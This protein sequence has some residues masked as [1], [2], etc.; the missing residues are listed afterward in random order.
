MSRPLQFLLQA[1]CA[2]LLLLFMPASLKELTATGAVHAAEAGLPLRDAN[3]QG[4]ALLHTFMVREQAESLAPA[5]AQ[6]AVAPVGSTLEPSLELAP[7]PALASAAT[8]QIRLVADAQTPKVRL[9]APLGMDTDSDRVTK[10]LPETSSEPSP[11]TTATPT[12]ARFDGA[13]VLASDPT[14]IAPE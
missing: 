7:R 2:C 10:A 4:I 6:I 14:A 5:Q 12:S 11:T 9:A 13:A 1:G 3:A 8:T